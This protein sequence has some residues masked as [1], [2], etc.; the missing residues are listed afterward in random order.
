MGDGN[1]QSDA[2]RLSGTGYA[3]QDIKFWVVTTQFAFGTCMTDGVVCRAQGRCAC[4]TNLTFTSESNAQ[5]TSG[6]ETIDDAFGAQWD[7]TV[8][9][10]D[11]D[12]LDP[13]GRVPKPGASTAEIKVCSPR[14]RGRGRGC[15]TKVRG[16]GRGRALCQG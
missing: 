2:V 5:L 8:G 7:T 14:G 1:Q 13:E 4:K 10:V 16:C 9:R 11:A 6:G 15:G 3:T 12:A